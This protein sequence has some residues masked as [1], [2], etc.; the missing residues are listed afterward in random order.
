MFW[1]G[2]RWVS[3]RKVPAVWT[4]TTRRDRMRQWI[5]TIPILLLVPALILPLLAA[6]AATQ[7][8]LKGQPS[9]GAKVTLIGT[10]FPANASLTAMWDDTKSLGSF[11]SNGNGSFSVTVQIPR[12][13]TLGN[14]HLTVVQPVASTTNGAKL[15]TISNSGRGKKQ[16]SPT[17][18]SAPTATP[19][20]AGPV[21]LA[22]LAVDVVPASTPTPDPTAAPTD[23]PT[24]APTDTPTPRP[25]A[26]P[27]TPTPVPTP[28]PT[29]VPT[30]APTAVP[31]PA[32][33]A[34]PTPAPTAVPTPAPTAVPTPTPTAVPTATP[35]PAPTPTPTPVPTP[36]P[37]AVPTPTPT[38]VPTP[39]PTP[40][41]TATPAPT[42]TPTASPCPASLQ[43]AI[44]NPPT[45]G[46]LRLGACTFLE[47]VTVNRAMTIVGP[48]VIDGGNVRTT[49]MTV[50]AAGVTVDGLTMRNAASGGYQ[51]GS[52]V[53]DGYNNFTLRNAS[54]SGGSYADLRLWNSAG[55]S[56]TGSTFSSGRAIGILGWN[57]TDSLISVNRLTGNNTTGADPGNEA[58]G[59]K[60]GQSSRIT[61]A[62]NEVD[63]NVGVGIWCDVYCATITITGNGVHDNTHQGI[64]YEISSGGSITNNRVWEN[65]WAFT[66]WGWGGGIVVSSSG[67]T[68]VA[69]NTVAWNADGVIVISQSRSGSP[70]V[71]GNHVHDNV[72]AIAPQPGDSSDKMAVAWLQDWSGVMYAAGSNNTGSGNDYWASVPE[73]Q[74]AR[75][76]WNGAISSLS[77]FNA[78]P[79]ED[80]GVYLSSSSLA[81]DLSVAGMPG[82]PRAH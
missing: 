67:T 28:A 76:N 25:T 3:E 26:V 63:N 9:P 44:N 42:P 78:T 15:S 77:S 79:G 51:S 52:L 54:L 64:L 36:T 73:P 59:I 66:S 81:T 75:F 56:V 39:T 14:H 16:P 19:A 23:P 33:T 47:S 65:G 69:S 49:W 34:V 22:D 68:D 12:R 58:G 74:W 57:V 48:A 6:S 55:D 20:P 17:P 35:T 1:D 8:S 60:L 38:A 2:E 27:P 80:N 62:N 43:T 61:I 72:V 4:V 82:S 37:T 71:A 70:T 31:T 53:V 32:P 50:A 18:T 29:A 30:P 40:V 13:T 21:Q 10:Y 11:K 5:A 24:P 7:L 41:P 46:T 45:G